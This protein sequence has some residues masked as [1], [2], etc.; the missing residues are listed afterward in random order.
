VAAAAAAAAAAAVRR[1]ADAG[2]KP[3][4]TPLVS[5]VV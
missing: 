4:K 1:A 2:S 5:D 3:E